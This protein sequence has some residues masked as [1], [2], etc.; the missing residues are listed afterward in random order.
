[1]FCRV[2]SR[3]VLRSLV[4]SQRCVVLSF[5]VSSLLKLNLNL[6]FL[7]TSMGYESVSVTSLGYES[8]LKD[9]CMLCGAYVIGLKDCRRVSVLMLWHARK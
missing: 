3:C 1:M 8:V 2:V 6:E 7:V 5:R 4:V 9:A